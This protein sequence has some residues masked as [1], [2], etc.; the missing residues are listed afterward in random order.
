M[1]MPQECASA[2]IPVAGQ[3]RLWLTAGSWWIGSWGKG[4]FKAPAY[5]DGG[6]R[7]GTTG[8]YRADKNT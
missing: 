5:F 6:R 1:E 3:V 4:R 2:A 8:M 7:K